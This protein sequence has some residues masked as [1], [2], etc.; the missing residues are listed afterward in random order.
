MNEEVQERLLSIYDKMGELATEYGPEVMDMTLEV[1][2]INAIQELVIGF[3]VSVATAVII[4]VTFRVT[5][6]FEGIEKDMP[7]IMMATIAFMFGAIGIYRLFIIWNW[8]GVFNPKLK[9]AHDIL[10]SA[11]DKI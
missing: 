8:I 6:K 1:V 2:R 4:M 5:K 3:A 11:L 10:Q 7:R 9:L